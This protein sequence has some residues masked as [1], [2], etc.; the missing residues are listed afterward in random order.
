MQNPQTLKPLPF[1]EEMARENGAQDCQHCGELDFGFGMGGP[2]GGGRCF[3]CQGIVQKYSALMTMKFSLEVFRELLANY[4]K[5]PPSGNRSAFNSDMIG[6][7][8]GF[9]NL[10]R[11][12]NTLPPDESISVFKDILN[13][14]SFIV[15]NQE[16]LGGYLNLKLG[17]ITMVLGKPSYTYTIKTLLVFALS[18]YYFQT[19]QTKPVQAKPIQP[20]FIQVPLVPEASAPAAAVKRGF[21]S[22]LFS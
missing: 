2:D 17:K 16:P 14:V 1:L 9:L 12:Q 6:T 15:G 21:F 10:I 5:V 19:Y 22:R 8:T 3:Y 11:N 18:I 13:E 7:M 4:D 20:A